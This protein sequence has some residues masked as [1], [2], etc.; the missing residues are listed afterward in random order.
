[1]GMR[2]ITGNNLKK[3]ALSAVHGTS[4]ASIGTNLKRGISYEKAVYYLI[5]SDHGSGSCRY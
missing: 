5:L 3:A 1:M 4:E 2:G